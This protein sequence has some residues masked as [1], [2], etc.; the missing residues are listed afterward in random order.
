M[1]QDRSEVVA[2]ELWDRVRRLA[3]RVARFEE[4][5]AT[6]DLDDDG[7]ARLD[8]LRVRAARAADRAQLADHLADMVA[9]ARAAARRGTHIP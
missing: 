1:S 3:E 9:E 7:R 5:D 4:A 6:G 8:A 2:D